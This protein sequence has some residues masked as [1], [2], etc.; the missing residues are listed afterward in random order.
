[1]HD[2]HNR[3]VPGHRRR[4]LSRRRVLG[5]VTAG[6]VAIGAAGIGWAAFAGSAGV[7][8]STDPATTNP[9][10][11]T[12]GSIPGLQVVNDSS[13][14]GSCR[15]FTSYPVVPGAEGMTAAMRTYVKERLATYLG[16]GSGL[17]DMRNCPKE[18]ELNIS[19][20]LLTASGD[21]LAN[22]LTTLQRGGA[23]NGTSTRVFWY[24]GKAGKNVNST[25]LIAKDSLDRL[26]TTVKGNLKGREGIDAVRLDS[27]FQDAKNREVH[28]QDM[29]FTPEGD[30]VVT[31]ARGVVAASSVERTQ[32]RIPKQ[33]VSPL[34]SDFGRRAQQQAIAPSRKLDLGVPSPPPTSPVTM[35]TTTASKEPR[36]DCRKVMC[37]AL[38]FDDG[39][40]QY[41]AQLLDILARYKVRA[42][43]YLVGQNATSYQDLV[44]AQNEAGHEL[45]NHS[46]NHSDLTK[47]SAEEIR[48]QMTRTDAA[49]AKAAGTV[50]DTLRP[51]YGAYNDSVRRNAGKPLM[52]WSVDPEDWKYHDSDRVAKHI[53]DKTR[54]GDIVLLHDIHRTSVNAVPRILRGLKARGY[55]FVTVSE[56]FSGQTLKA[57]A[58]YRYNPAA[59]GREN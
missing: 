11:A 30:M 35:A 56:L 41:T 37:V 59:Y 45:G 21:I 58:V 1:M 49:I 55:H 15:W 31:F 8:R 10:P 13:E 24:D 17:G 27:A 53:L 5:L 57:G 48:S 32:A 3:S 42:T 50:P 47:L 23:A 38:T 54:P 29:A 46:W 25:A 52:L 39:P 36:T 6:A 43:F 19:F 14:H 16:K 44:R 22:R 26:A 34:L 18:R 12:P 51:P 9:P 2:T 40:A 33:K 7:L 4:T 28:L 20:D